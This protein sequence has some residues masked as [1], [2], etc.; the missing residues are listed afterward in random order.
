LNLVHPNGFSS[1]TPFF[2]IQY[3]DWVLRIG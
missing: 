1:S 2:G 3:S